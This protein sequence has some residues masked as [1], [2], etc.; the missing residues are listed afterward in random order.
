MIQADADPALEFIAR[1]AAG[2]ERR[3]ELLSR[4]DGRAV[5]GFGLS[6]S[7]ARAMSDS[8]DQRRA[9]GRES[10]QRRLQIARWWVQARREWE[11]EVAE[12][13]RRACEEFAVALWAG[14][15]AKA[16]G[17]LGRWPKGVELL[18]VMGV[19]MQP[20]SERGELKNGVEVTFEVKS[21]SEIGPQARRPSH[22][23][24]SRVGSRADGTAGERFTEMFAWPSRSHR[25]GGAFASHRLARLGLATGVIR[26]GAPGRVVAVRWPEMIGRRLAAAVQRHTFV[27][28]EGEI[29]LVRI[30]GLKIWSV[31]TSV[32][33]GERQHPAGSLRRPDAT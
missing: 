18:L 11:A 28:D 31:G 14:D 10:R 16:P 17:K 32:A 13:R 22:N 24:D 25:D 1:E 30:D 6:T 7:F 9:R 33:C 29:A 19:N 5:D 26:P 20:V 3:A 23:A 2:D 15:P 4:A 21:L 27:E 12:C 8:A